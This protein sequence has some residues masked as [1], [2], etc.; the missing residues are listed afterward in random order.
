MKKHLHGRRHLRANK[1]MTE[2][3]RKRQYVKLA[4]AVV[5]FQRSLPDLKESLEGFIASFLEVLHKIFETIENMP[6]ERVVEII[7]EE[8]AERLK[9]LFPRRIEL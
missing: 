7:G 6:Y 4:K 5:M 3:R 9:E 1:S 2:G 8:K